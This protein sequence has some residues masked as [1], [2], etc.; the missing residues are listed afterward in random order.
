M[1]VTEETRLA[2]IKQTSNLIDRLAPQ[3]TKALPRHIRPD[4]LARI[5]LTA[6]RV[7]PKLAECNEGSF[8]GALLQAAALGL[9][10]NTPTGHAYL[11]PYGSQCTLVIGYRGYVELAHRS[12]LLKDIAAKA[13]FDGDKFDYRFGLSPH[14]DHV[15]G[16]SR[17]AARLT[18]AWCAGRL[19]TGGTFMEVLTRDDIEA[20]RKRSASANSSSS[21]WKTDYAAMARKTA[22][23]AVAW[24]LPASP[25]LMRAEAI[26]RAES[27]LLGQADAFDPVIIEALAAE[28][29]EVPN[30]VEAAATE[31]S[32]PSALA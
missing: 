21:P 29:V 16:A 11:I 30:T 26:D 6:V 28:G 12:G 18:H 32:K 4:R 5:V 17:D 1:T 10:P 19:T 27:G 7:N 20:R 25:E 13:V 14:L 15:P 23:R 22:V 31:P 2:R 3:L 8:C 24:Q 9:E